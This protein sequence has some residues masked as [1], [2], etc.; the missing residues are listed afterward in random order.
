MTGT[1]YTLSI[2]H[3]SKRARTY[4]LLCERPGCYH[5]ASKTHVRHRIFKLS[6]NHTSVKVLLYLGKTSLKQEYISVGCIPPTAVAVSAT[7]HPR[8]CTPPATNVPCHADPLPWMPPSMPHTY[9]CHTHL[10]WPCTLPLWTEWLTDRCKNI[11][12]PQ[13]RWGW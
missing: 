7:T 11:T 6:Q 3:Y 10:P 1:T 5:N 2:C 12:L 13:L 4:H 8:L 9:P